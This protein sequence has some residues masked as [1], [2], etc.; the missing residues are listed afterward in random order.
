ML[1][2]QGRAERARAS[3]LAARKKSERARNANEARRQSVSLYRVTVMTTG[4]VA[5]GSRG[6]N[7]GTQ[8]LK[9][10]SGSGDVIDI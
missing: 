9:G 4:V 8:Y 5:N 3:E 2:A 10:K 6:M 1:R 7:G